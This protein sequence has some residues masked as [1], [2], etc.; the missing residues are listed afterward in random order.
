MTV[1]SE[2]RTTSRGDRA[3]PVARDDS[4]PGPL[5]SRLHSAAI[6]LLRRV[7]AEDPVTGL[8][9][10]R[11]SALSVLVFRGPTTLG[12]LASA[13]QVSAPTM[14]RLASA[15]EADGYV[16]RRPDPRDGRAVLLRATPAGARVL[17]EGRARRLRH[18]EELL[19]HLDERER[20]TLAQAVALLDRALAG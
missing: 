10:A 11:L 6:R 7:R 9:P 12:E 18:L 1:E 17:E 2:R 16:V 3:P 4:G 13:E 14:S 15:L 5:A 19:A 8:T 20:A